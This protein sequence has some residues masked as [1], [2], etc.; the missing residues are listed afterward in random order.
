MLIHIEMK[1]DIT[2]WTIA[3]GLHILLFLVNFN[4]YRT[5]VEEKLLP[6]VEVEYIIPEEVISARLVKVPG[7]PPQTFKEKLKH[8]FTKE[9]APPK[10]EEIMAGKAPSKLEVNEI[11][12]LSQ[13]K[14]LID[15]KGSLSRKVDLSPINNSKEKLISESKEE[16]ILLASKELN[17][18]DL[19]LQDLKDKEYK[20]AKKDLPFQIANR[21]EIKGN[22]TDIVGI[23]LGKET[24]KSILT[25]AP[26]LKDIKGK[27]DFGEGVFRVVKQEDQGKLS[28]SEVLANLLVMAKEEEARRLEEYGSGLGSGGALTGKEGF[29]GNRGGPIL[30]SGRGGSGGEQAGLDRGVKGVERIGAGLGATGG[31]STGGSSTGVASQGSSPG[32]AKSEEKEAER[33]FKKGVVF[34]RSPREKE[35]LAG[36]GSEETSSS[37]KPEKEVAKK[38][39]RGRVIFEIRG[40]LSQRTVLHKVIPSYPEWAEKEGIEAG[41]SVHFVVLSNGEV[42]DNIYV[43]RTSGYPVIDQ[44]VM[45]AL[46]QWQFASLEGDF[47]GKE[48]WGVLTFYFSLGGRT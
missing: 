36:S 13:D 16:E 10:K 12:S 41:V 31:S 22:G 28:G 17:L 21:E 2:C 30:E 40:P 37:S 46:R 7:E 38:G 33:T 20:V 42:K 3:I 47:Y 39:P 32:E 26:T 25:Q 19:K 27:G 6:I 14:T 4:L 34:S 18:T 15:K 8:F 1:H 5:G 35:G 44:L 48:E 43:V 24:S 11:G 23:D 9:I 45:E 29:K